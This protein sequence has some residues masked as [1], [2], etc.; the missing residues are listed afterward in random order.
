MVADLE[1]VA[2]WAKIVGFL[3]ML[4]RLKSMSRFLIAWVIVIIA[5]VAFTIHI[6]IIIIIVIVIKEVRAFIRSWSTCTNTIFSK[7]SWHL[8]T[9]TLSFCFCSQNLF[10]KEIGTEMRLWITAEGLLS[11]KITSSFCIMCDYLPDDFY[12][13]TV[14]AFALS[15][16]TVHYRGIHVGWWESVGF[17]QE[18]DYAQQNGPTDKKENR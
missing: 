9:V 8:H 14:F 15:P 6:I 11:F 17:I 12:I 4:A 16:L 3:H 5:A 13:F 10:P 2:S 7:C 18:W 1:Y